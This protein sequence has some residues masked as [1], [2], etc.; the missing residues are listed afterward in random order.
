MLTSKHVQV[1]KQSKQSVLERSKCQLRRQ[2]GSWLSGQR[3]QTQRDR[4]G[5]LPHQPQPLHHCQCNSQAL[6]TKQLH[7]AVLRTQ[8]GS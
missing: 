5:R 4:Q 2:L 6:R 1:D 3:R 8:E 7:L